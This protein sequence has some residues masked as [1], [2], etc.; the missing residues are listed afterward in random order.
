MPDGG[1]LTLETESGGAG[2]SRA[3]PHGVRIRAGA[4]VELS[5]RDT[6]VGMDDR[7]LA[8]IFEPFFT[9]KGVGRGTGLGL[10]TV[11][12]IVKQSNGYVFAES[13]AGQ[14]TTLRILLPV[15]TEQ[16]SAGSGNAR[17]A[18]GE[19]GRPSSSWMT[20]RWCAR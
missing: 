2:G 11:Y 16:P 19:A 10:S 18:A 13:A 4:Y 9:T 3:R 8:H 14:G 12:G 17:T 5:V 7:T 1:T 20:S 15:A 6:G